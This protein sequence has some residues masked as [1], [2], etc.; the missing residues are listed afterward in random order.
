MAD[1]VLDAMTITRNN[2]FRGAARCVYAASA[3]AFPTKIEDVIDPS[4]YALASGWSDL[5]PTNDDGF[6]VRRSV[7]VFDGIA[8]DQLKTNLDEGE[9]ESWSMEAET[10]IMDTSLE[11]MA[12]VWQGGTLE[13]ISA[14]T[15]TIAQ[16]ALPLDAPTSFTS[17]RLAFIQQDEKTAR[18]RV[19]AFRDAIPQVDGSDLKMTSGEGSPLPTKFKLKRDTAIALNAGQFGKVFQEDVT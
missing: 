10:T 4:T 14:G 12:I 17:R 13:T 1:T 9:P 8:I 2:V 11:K 6:T 3:K 18:L 7:E 5:G 19:F 15:G 16:H